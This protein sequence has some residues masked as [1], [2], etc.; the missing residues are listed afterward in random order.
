MTKKSKT[1][2][3]VVVDERA[4][5]IPADFKVEAF[6]VELDAMMLA[7]MPASVVAYLIRTGFTTSMNSAGYMSKADWTKHKERGRDPDGMIASRALNRYRAICE[8]T[9]SSGRKTFKKLTPA[10]KASRLASKLSPEDR[11]A[12]LATL[13]S[14]EAASDDEEPSRFREA[15]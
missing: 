3:P 2:K 1:P 13:T 4:I 12:L 6:G 11:A 10:E 5:R 8:G 7:N 15:A 9:A 14:D